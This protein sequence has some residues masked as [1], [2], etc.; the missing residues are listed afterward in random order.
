MSQA[1]A[2]PARPEAI[3]TGTSR[4]NFACQKCFQPLKLDLSFT[5][6]DQNLYAEVTGRMYFPEYRNSMKQC[7]VVV[8]PSVAANSKISECH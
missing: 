7:G 6:I 1:E 3:K 4:V 8:T 5:N 2:P